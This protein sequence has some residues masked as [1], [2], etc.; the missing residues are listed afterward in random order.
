VPRLFKCPIC[1][2]IA[3]LRAFVERLRHLVREG[4]LSI[5]CGIWLVNKLQE[6]S[7]DPIFVNLPRLAG[8]LLFRKLLDR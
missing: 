1:V 7:M 3:P 8:M 2:G 4:I 6:R 5:S